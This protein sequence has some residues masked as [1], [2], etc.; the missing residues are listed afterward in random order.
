MSTKANSVINPAAALGGGFILVI[1]HRLFG[2]TAYFSHAFGIVVKGKPEVLVQNG[3]LHRRNM[4]WNHISE[5]DLEEDMRLHASI[6]AGISALLKL[7]DLRHYL[8]R[9]SMRAEVSKIQ[10]YAIIGNG[11]SAA[12]IS[13]RGSL[14]WLCWPRFDSASIFGAILDAK[15]GGYWS[16]RPAGAAKI[17][18]QYIDN[19][20]VLETT[21][22]I[23]SGKM[24]VTDFMPVTSEEEKKRRL[25]PEHEIIRQ[26]R[27]DEGE[28]SIVVDFDPR[29]NYGGIVPK[30]KNAGKFGWRIDIGTNVFTLRSEVELVPSDGDGLSAKFTLKSGDVVAFSLTFSAEAPGVVPP[31]D[32]LATE[33]LN[34]TID[35]WRQWAAQSNYHGP[36]ERHVTRSALVLKLLSYAPS[37][38]IVAAPTTSLPERIGGDLNWDYRFAWLRDASFTLHAL[39]GLGYKDDAEAFVDWLLHATRLTR[40]ELRVVY[41]VFGERPPPECEL[42]QLRGHRGSRPVRI[43]NAAI[44]QV[45]LDIYG[46]VVE[47]VSHFTRESRKLDRDMQKMLRQCAEYVCEH[48]YQPDNGMWEERDERRHYTHSRLMCWVALDRILD[49]QARGQLDGISIEKCKAERQR[50]REEIEMR[51]WNSNLGAYAQACGSH[52]IDASALLLAYHSFEDA[53]S[54]RM[55]QT[56]ERIRERLV[57][58]LGLVYRNERSMNRHEGA[59]AVC[60]FWEADFLARGGKLSEA[61]KVF[62]AALA[63]ANDV[64][65]FAE[66][67]D[68]ETG[69]ALGNFPQGFT[70]L[71]VINAALALRDCEGGTVG[72]KS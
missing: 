18:R 26:I 31:L 29:L 72:F 51:A 10:D 62:E 64:D 40:P 14:D 2:L 38:A 36:Y 43:G 15:T 32:K 27:C 47:A 48:W 42:P 9:L 58:R 24:V 28:T 23:G 52:E 13:N 12:L 66:E 3:M 7:N 49:M 70:H 44:E 34:L 37:G 68:P 8:C 17:R 35:W 4:V 22:S 67:I 19:T 53:S 39:F 11:R 50:I 46:E 54:Q 69:D 5:H 61:R 57:P 59:F 45:Q 21:F 16:I 63:Y 20:N 33:K 25:W 1:I 56:H 71:G 60:S 65:L 6:A 55:R 41:D 30:I